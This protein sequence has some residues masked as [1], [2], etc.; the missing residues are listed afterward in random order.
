[1]P[2]LRLNPTVSASR[3]HWMTGY[4][5]SQRQTSPPKPAQNGKY[6]WRCQPFLS[7]PSPS[8]SRATEPPGQYRLPRDPLS[9]TEDRTRAGESDKPMRVASWIQD[10][11]FS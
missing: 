10:V 4:K 3:N 11:T 1:M 2:I 9:K 6:E 8:Q 5:P 7:G